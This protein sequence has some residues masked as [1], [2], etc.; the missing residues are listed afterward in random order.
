[1]EQ[2]FELV[3]LNTQDFR[4]I[5]LVDLDF[6]GKKF[7][8]ITGSNGAA[9]TSVIESIMA[10]ILGNKFFTEQFGRT[11]P[12]WTVI[13]KEKDK[14][15]VA[16]KLRGGDR[17]IEIRRSFTRKDDGST[18]GTLAIKDTEGKKLDQSFLDGLL[19]G[20][21]VDPSYFARL[22]LKE[23][24]DLIKRLAGIDDEVFAKERQQ[25]EQDRLFADRKIRELKAKVG[26]E[27]EQA[28]EVSVDEL[29]A[30]RQLAQERFNKRELVDRLRAE[31]HE[32]EEKL[33]ELQARESEAVIQL[34]SLPA[35]AEGLDVDD[36]DRQIREAG[37]QNAKAL[38]YREWQENSRSLRNAEQEKKSAQEAIDDVA[39]RRQEAIAN[40]K[41]PF[42]G[43]S[44]D[45][46][47]GVMINGISIRQMSESQQ[48]GISAQIGMH[49]APGLRLMCVRNGSVL[50]PKSVATLRRIADQS[51]YQL[52]V[53]TVGEK[54]GGDRI[55]MRAGSAISKFKS[56]DALEVEARGGEAAS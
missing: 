23:Q 56:D 32:L 36:L 31:I 47:A 45:D 30:K 22:G 18:G 50:D 52:I 49:M 28:E 6:D 9:K 19:N 8:E 1:M 51:G 26:S 40:A 29:V 4:S 25:H 3:G 34:E 41:L 55:V 21:T 17:V 13:R 5:E 7:V 54:A 2:T 24:V 11:F 35:A 38:R 37:E 46:D 44:L 16:V 43:L 27:P 20:F 10:A 53:E 15:T 42:K 12:V 39:K 48:L 33:S 14:A